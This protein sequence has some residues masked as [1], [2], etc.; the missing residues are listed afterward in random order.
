MSRVLAF[1]DTH[2]PF[3]R[4]GAIKFLREVKKEYKCDTIVNVGDMFDLHRI[5]R[6][7][8]NPDAMGAK[9]EY[10]EGI[11]IAKE[12]YTTFP[13]VKVCVGNHDSR[14]YK[15]A[16]EKYF[17]SIMLPKYNDWTKSPTG[18]DWKLQHIVDDVLYIHGTASKG[19]EFPHVQLAKQA[20]MSLVMGHAHTVAGIHYMA[21]DNDLIFAMALGCMMDSKSYAA[22]YAEELIKKPIVS[23]GVIIDG[24][25][26]IL[27][28]MPLG[29]KVQRR[30]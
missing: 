22:T 30:K 24:T 9:E 11:E 15:Q 8:P 21:S 2:L 17:P 25:L 29:T 7:L 23:C 27:I 18:W 16:A 20:R 1:G 3:I 19:G 28:P 6:H 12:L 14:Y 26:P 4:G 10:L 13:K 5:S